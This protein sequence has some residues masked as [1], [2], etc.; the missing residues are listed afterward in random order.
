VWALAGEKNEW[1]EM[2][3]ELARAGW[4]GGLGR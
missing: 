3:V 1:V 2:L 4:P